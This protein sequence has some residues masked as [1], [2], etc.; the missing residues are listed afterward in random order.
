MTIDGTRANVVT[1][2][3]VPTLSRYTGY[4]LR[5]AFTQAQQIGTNLVPPPNSVR[6][7]A[8][9]SLVNDRGPMSQRELGELLQLNRTIVVKLVDGLEDRGLVHRVRNVADRRSYA[10]QLSAAGRRLLRTAKPRLIAGDARLTASLSEPERRRLKALLRQLVSTPG[11]VSGTL[12]SDATGYL[13]AHAY[14]SMRREGLARLAPLGVEMR[15]VAVLAI[16]AEE[17]TSQQ[18]IAARLMVTAPVV[19]DLLDELSDAGF[20]ERSRDPGDRRANAV[21]LSSAGRAT[22]DA[23][24]AVYGQMQ[25]EVVQRV[26]RRGDADLR[27]LLRKL[28]DGV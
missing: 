18:R 9:L 10:L 13:I 17:S 6:D 4:L 3:V 23:A 19:V 27:R 7:I 22:L 25:A 26:G 14:H 15:Q 1:P 2:P 8:V 21:A 12:L 11:A 16:I 20:V 24:L 5:R 28:V